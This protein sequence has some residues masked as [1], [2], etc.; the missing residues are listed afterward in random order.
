[1]I[2]KHPEILFFS[3]VLFLISYSVS[4][5]KIVGKWKTVD[6]RNGN[7]KA[8]VELYKE[9]GLLNGRVLKIVEKG[10]ENALCIKCKGDLKDKPVEGM[11]IIFG[12]EDN[13]EGVFKGKKLF[14]PEQAMTFR[15]RIWI[16]PDN[17]DQLKVRGY[18]AFLYRTQTWLR[19]V[20]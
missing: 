18:L 2:K 19:V 17:S 15:G 13:G 7:P 16:D 4:S 11:K 5:Q 1:M 9:N 6:D 10:K 3:I 8:I 14:D 20:D 12:F